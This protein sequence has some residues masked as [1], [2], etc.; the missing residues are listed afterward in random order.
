MGCGGMKA[1]DE[2]WVLCS[3]ADRR[4]PPKSEPAQSKDSEPNIKK[5]PRRAD[6]R[7]MITGLYSDIQ[8]PLQLF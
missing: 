1:W 6:A 5:V 7:M 4:V 8:N 2:V 3:V